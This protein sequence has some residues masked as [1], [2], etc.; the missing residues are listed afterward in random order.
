M[1]SRQRSRMWD[2]VPVAKTIFARGPEYRTFRTL[3]ARYVVQGLS[4][5]IRYNGGQGRGVV[6]ELACFE[7][8]TF[9]RRSGL[10]P[11]GGNE[12][13]ASSLAYWTDEHGSR[14]SRRAAA[15]VVQRHSRGAAQNKPRPDDR[16][17]PLRF[18]A[19]AS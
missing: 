1:C 9:W 15:K 2:D 14:N 7:R 17:R 6:P 13:Q 18:S 3:P 5:T 8:K 10:Q 19:A 4:G 16:A 11:D 12:R